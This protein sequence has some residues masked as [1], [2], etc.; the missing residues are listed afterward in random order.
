MGGESGGDDGKEGEQDG[1]AGLR[2][3]SKALPHLH[4]SY[5]EYRFVLLHVTAPAEKVTERAESVRRNLLR[6]Y[7]AKEPDSETVTSIA[8]DDFRNDDQAVEKGESGAEN[9][10]AASLNDS[11]LQE[12]EDN[13]KDLQDEGQAS[14]TLAEGNDDEKAVESPSK[15][16]MDGSSSTVEKMLQKISSNVSSILD[17]PIWHYYA[18]LDNSNGDGVGP[19]LV[20]EGGAHAWSTVVEMS[21]VNGEG[22]DKDKNV[23][24]ESDSLPTGAILSDAWLRQSLQLPA[25]SPKKKHSSISPDFLEMIGRWRR[26]CREWD[27]L[28]E[29]LAFVRTYKPSLPPLPHDMLLWKLRPRLRLAA[30]E[31]AQLAVNVRDQFFNP[32]GEMSKSTDL[33]VTMKMVLLTPA[34]G[35][36]PLAKTETSRFPKWFRLDFRAMRAHMVRHERASMNFP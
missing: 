1:G 21:Q 35:S 9:S 17:M 8:T 29:A 33:D 13:G 22:G 10:D 32:R 16:D 25:M 18:T 24:I 36:A 6:K 4:D 23:D 19:T 28:Y 30:G 34:I 14:S 27:A 15:D 3:W 11:H 20:N 5:P 2:W 12:A 31:S 7:A 26:F